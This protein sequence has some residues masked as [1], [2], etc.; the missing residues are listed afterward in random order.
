MEQR[1][2]GGELD[3]S[4]EAVHAKPACFFLAKAFPE[5]QTSAA[6]RLTFEVI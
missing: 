5:S 1:P 4:P 3:V 6:P 2:L